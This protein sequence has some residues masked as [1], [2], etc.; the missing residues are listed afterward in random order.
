MKAKLVIFKH[1]QIKGINYDETFALMA[2]MVIARTFLAVKK[3]KRW[4]FHQMDVHNMFLHSDLVE[5][6]YMKVPISF[7][8]IDPNL[9][10]KLKKSLYGLKQAPHCWFMLAT[11][12]K[13]YG[14]A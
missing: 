10:C 3:I 7:K 5:E 6:V 2:K 8:N 14:F 12:L 1:H 13:H 9:I 4:E 11:T